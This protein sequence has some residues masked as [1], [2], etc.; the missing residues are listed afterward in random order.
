[1]PDVL[2]IHPYSFLHVPN[3]SLT[4][5]HIS[6]DLDVFGAHIQKLNWCLCKNNTGLEICFG[7]FDVVTVF[8]LGSQ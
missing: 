6:M 4:N 8:Q 2:Q 1:M 5:M 3:Q 7:D